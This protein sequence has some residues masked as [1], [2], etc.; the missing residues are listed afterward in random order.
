MIDAIRGELAKYA[1]QMSDYLDGI[2]ASLDSYKFIVER[3]PNGITID[4]AFK[5]T[6]RAKPE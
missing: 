2:D 3:L 1:Q 5:V 6:I 4:I